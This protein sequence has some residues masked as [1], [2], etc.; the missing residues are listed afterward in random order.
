[1]SSSCLLLVHFSFKVETIGDCYVAITGCPQPQKRHAEIMVKFANECMLAMNKV[2]AD[3]V[4]S[5]GEDTKDLGFRVGLH[6]G[7][8]TAG[9]LRGDKGR[10]QLFG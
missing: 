6:S 1:L 2:T 8:T 5:L 9:V 10:F 3:L 4:G 7:S